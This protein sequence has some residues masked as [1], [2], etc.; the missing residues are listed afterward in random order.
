VGE[1]PAREQFGREGSAR[2]PQVRGHKGASLQGRTRPVPRR[3]ST[4]FNLYD[5]ME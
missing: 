2:P 3:R 5:S 1:L 4:V